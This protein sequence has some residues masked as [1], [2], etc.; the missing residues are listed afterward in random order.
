MLQYERFYFDGFL[1][2][3][4]VVRGPMHKR[5]SAERSACLNVESVKKWL[6]FI[7]QVTYV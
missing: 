5:L 7:L 3:F 2:L 1:V 4:G 6:Q